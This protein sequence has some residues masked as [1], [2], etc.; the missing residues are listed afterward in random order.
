MVSGLIML[1]AIVTHQ[2][3]VTLRDVTPLARITGEYEV[4]VVPVTSS[5]HSLQEF[6]QAFKAHPESI[7][8]GGG[9]AGG[10]DQI[11]A[12]L[13]SDAVGVAESTP[14]A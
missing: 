13:V 6:I 4:I 5:F 3:P 9:S 2:P 1:A 7:S 14:K 8:W 11:L 10:T 12:G